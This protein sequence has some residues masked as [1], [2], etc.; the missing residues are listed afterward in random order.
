MLQEELDP[1]SPTAT[2]TLGDLLRL[3][4]GVRMRQL[5]WGP[6]AE[7]F[8]LHGAGSAS[9]ELLL[10]GAPVGV[11]GTSAPHSHEVF[12][13]EMS[14]FTV[15]SGGAG[16]LF[17]PEAAGGAVAVEPRF[18]V[19]DRMLARAVG[20]EGVDGYERASFQVARPLGADAAFFLT[21]ESRR[22]DGYFAGTREVD[23]QFAGR[24]DRRWPGGI[25]T[26]IGYRVYDGSGRTGGTDGT[27]VRALETDRTDLTAR[28]LSP[29]SAERG[30][31]LEVG[32][33]R[34]NIAHTGVTA[35]STRKILA[36]SLRATTDLP[37]WFGLDW[38]ARVEGTRWRIER[39]E[40]ETIDRFWRTGSA[41]RSSAQLGEGRFLTGTVRADLEQDR[42][43]ALHG[44]LEGEWAWGGLSVFSVASRSERIPDRGAEGSANEVHWG[45][46]LGL[47]ARGSGLA[48]Q[49]VAFGTRIHD[50]RPEPS[51][52]AVR[53]REPV[54]APP[55]GTGEIRGASVALDTDFLRLPLL[56]VLGDLQV[57]TS[58]TWLEAELEETGERLPRR[59]R[60]TWT[61]EGSLARALFQDDLLFRVRGR[62]TNYGDRVD[63]Q[64][65]AVTDAWITDVILEAEIADAI[66]FYR[67]HDLLERADEVE[68]GIRFPG[69][70]HTF[71]LTWRF[72]E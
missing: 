61:G 69:F 68:P 6:T 66:L 30:T 22:I 41:V 63:D 35:P 51:F 27:A 52:A 15:V 60:H 45:A 57:K 3:R 56:R 53:A 5:S 12:L 70:S 46:E 29:W 62:L 49:A 50:L 10:G 48:A 2:A 17:G 26:S 37:A 9:G 13:S 23:R 1:V 32:L 18:P 16:A 42:R 8:S 20:E 24:V 47:R 14:S 34:E 64:G 44:R 55:L 31:L 11:P 58:F 65:A 36:P 19:H 25:E 21:T 38:V 72:W 71:G 28:V 4:P 40:A 43:R 59:A 67:F 7:S 33:R 39:Q 54:L